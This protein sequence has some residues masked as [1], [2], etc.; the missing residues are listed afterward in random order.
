MHK[1]GPW[2]ETILARK[3]KHCWHCRKDIVKPHHKVELTISNQG[4]KK[5]FTIFFSAPA[6]DVWIT[7][8]G[9][10]KTAF[11]SQW[12][13]YCN[14]TLKELLA[15]LHSKLRVVCQIH[16]KKINSVFSYVST[17]VWGGWNMN[18]YSMCQWAVGQYGMIHSKWMNECELLQ[19]ISL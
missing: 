2:V 10:L 5:P 15:L 9:N 17:Q 19:P 1:W 4:R 6:L 11:S 14:G 18:S 16:Y 13:R 8:G 3:W 12:L 7:A